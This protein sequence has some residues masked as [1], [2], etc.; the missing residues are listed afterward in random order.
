MG[1]DDPL[2][3]EGWGEVEQ[4]CRTGSVL[5][6]TQVCSSSPL[7]THNLQRSLHPLGLPDFL[8]LGTV[9]TDTISEPFIPITKRENLSGSS[10]QMM[11]MPRPISSR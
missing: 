10:L 5:Y 1:Q 2:A 9:L 7:P 4:L 6:A 8:A 3:L 11:S